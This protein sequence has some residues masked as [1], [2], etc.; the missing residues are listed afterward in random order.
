[1]AYRIEFKQGV[2]KDLA[3]IPKALALKILD[4]IAA[5]SEEPRPDGCKKLKGSENTYRIRVN[6][7][8]VVYS[9]IDQKLVIQIIKIGHRK[10]IYQ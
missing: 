10:D 2:E 1:M 9:I 5:L 4:R 8:R 6:D 3:K 7:Y